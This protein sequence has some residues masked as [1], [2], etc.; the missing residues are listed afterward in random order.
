MLQLRPQ[1]GL[2]DALQ[3]SA[4]LPEEQLEAEHERYV[5][6]KQEKDLIRRVNFVESLVQRVM[7]QE[8]SCVTLR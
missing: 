8:K 4:R 1:S 2:E 3:L 6:E 5:L 7:Q